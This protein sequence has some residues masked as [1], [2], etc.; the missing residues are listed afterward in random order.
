MAESVAV[1][2]VSGTH[3]CHITVN[4][5]AGT[6]MILKVPPYARN[7][8]QCPKTLLLLLLCRDCVLEAFA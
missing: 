2:R 8:H 4:T 6:G 7:R 1:G 3:P 5:A